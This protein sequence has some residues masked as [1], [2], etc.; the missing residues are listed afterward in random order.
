MSTFDIYGPS[1]GTELHLIPSAA[2]ILP[3]QFAAVV[4]EAELTQ[5]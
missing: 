1:A 3:R 4:K 5:W 2:S